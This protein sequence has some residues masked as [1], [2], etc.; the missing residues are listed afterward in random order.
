MCRSLAARSSQ[1]FFPEKRF[2]AK[3]PKC[4]KNQFILSKNFSLLLNSRHILKSAQKSDS[5]DA[6]AD[7]F[8]EIFVFNSFCYF[9][10]RIKGQLR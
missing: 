9:L 1:R 7:Y 8:E 5:F 3:F 10:R 6:F 4:L 2:F